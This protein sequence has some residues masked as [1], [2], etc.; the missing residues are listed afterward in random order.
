MLSI[1]IIEVK[2]LYYLLH[3]KLMFA[4]FQVHE[5]HVSNDVMP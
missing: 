1:S 3:N 5:V 2:L 4:Y